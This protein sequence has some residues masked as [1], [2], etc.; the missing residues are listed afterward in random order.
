[1]K[2]LMVKSQLSNLRTVQMYTRQMLTLAENVFEF[3][4]LPELIDVAYM[5]K[6]LLRQGSI[7]FFKD[8]VLDTILAL[9]YTNLGRLDVYGRPTTI[10]VYG[11]NGY[12]KILKPEEYVIMYDNN[13]RY[14]LYIDILQ[15]AERIALCKRVTDI[16]ITH[17]KTP[18]L[19]KTTSDK[20]KTVE[21]IVNQIDSCV[22]GVVVYDSI[23]IDDLGVVQAP[24][25]FVSD[26]IDIHIEKEYAEFLRLIGIANLQTQKRERLIKDEMTASLG[27]TVASRYSRF[28]PRE[29]AVNMIN[30]KWGLDIKVKYYDG[31]PNSMEGDEEDVDVPDDES[32]VPDEPIYTN[33]E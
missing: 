12:S 4:D 10:Q 31:L 2:K 21:D 24:A 30:K 27:G 25:P 22:D 1:M 29:Q 18:R 8:D 33:N 28:Q 6:V 9:P 7:A 16:N 32:I 3:D 17:Q 19:W 26:K 14:S 23:D 15:M 20:K 11:E 5:N 13:G